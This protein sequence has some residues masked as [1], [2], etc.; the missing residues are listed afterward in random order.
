MTGILPIK[1]YGTHSA[2]NMFT[3]FSMTDAD[4][5]AEF[6]G[7]TEDEVT[8]SAETQDVTTEETDGTE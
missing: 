1:K 6:V 3:Q 8:E 5:L 7:F 4:L 2:L